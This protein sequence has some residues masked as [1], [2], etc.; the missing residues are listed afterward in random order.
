MYHYT[1]IVT[2]NHKLKKGSHWHLVLVQ[3]AFYLMMMVI[4]IAAAGGR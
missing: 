4:S 3:V 1:S 2:I